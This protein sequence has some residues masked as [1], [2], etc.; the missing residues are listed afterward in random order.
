M[1]I[2]L[3]HYRTKFEI[4]STLTAE[5]FARHLFREIRTD[6]EESYMRKRWEHRCDYTF[7]GSNF[8]F[9][10]NGFNKFNGIKRGSLHV[11]KELG[12][13]TVSARYEFQEIFFLCLIFSM[14][15]AI[16]LWSPAEWRILLLVLIWLVYFIN[17][18]V[19]YL[20]LNAYFKRKVRDT[21][22]DFDPS[23]EK[24]LL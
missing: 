22:I 15:P 12:E 3:L 6:L 8:R 20:R 7:S 1:F 21:F 11:S 19:S 16:S 2:P 4:Y 13:I 10:W 17:F 9:I 14:I 5:E 24:K 23:H 18:L